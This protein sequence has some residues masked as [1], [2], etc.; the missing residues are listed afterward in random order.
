[1]SSGGASGRDAFD[2]LSNISFGAPESG[3]RSSKKSKSTQPRTVAPVKPGEATRVPKG[4]AVE[5]VEI[6]S[7]NSKSNSHSIDDSPGRVSL[8][9]SH[10]PIEHAP[11][12]VKLRAS[13]SGKTNHR[14]IK[15][16]KAESG[17]KGPQSAAFDFLSGIS[18]GSPN[19]SEFSDRISK[20]F[21]SPPF[22]QPT[23]KGSQSM[24]SDVP[25][26]KA[27]ISSLAATTNNTEPSQEESWRAAS[28]EEEIGVHEATTLLFHHS[29]ASEEPPIFISN[30]Q[31]F[32]AKEFPTV[33]R[34]VV[35]EMLAGRRTMFAFPSATP[36]HTHTSSHPHSHATRHHNT[37]DT[38]NAGP[39]VKS[40][41]A[42]VISSIIC[43]SDHKPS[44]PASVPLTTAPTS[45]VIDHWAERLVVDS[46]TSDDD[47]DASTRHK[48]KPGVRILPFKK[49]AASTS[50]QRY[51]KPTPRNAEI[52][53]EVTARLPLFK[54]PHSHLM[55]SGTI[56]N[57]DGD[58]GADSP[59]PMATPR[60]QKLKS[61]SEDSPRSPTR[62]GTLSAAS[63]VVKASL[64]YPGTTNVSSATLEGQ[65]D[66]KGEND[67]KALGSPL[68]R[69]KTGKAG[70]R[71]VEGV[72]GE[73]RWERGGGVEAGEG[74]GG[75]VV[76]EV[77]VTGE[78]GEEVSTIGASEANM[79]ASAMGVAVEGLSSAT[80][81]TASNAAS[82]V[83]E[84]LVPYE[85]CLKSYD[86][87]FLEHDI[88]PAKYLIKVRLPGYTSS[89]L[90]VKPAKLVRQEENEAFKNRHS[91]LKTD[92]T[93]SKLRSVKRKMEQV[94]ISLTL[95]IACTAFSFVYFEK[96]V[97]RN[98]VSNHNAR[99]YGAVC[100]LLA[101][102]WYGV[103]M[104]SFASLIRELCHKLKLSTK[105]LLSQEF[106]IY[107][108]LKFSLFVEE[109]QV[110]PH[111][112]KLRSSP[113]YL[114]K[115]F[116]VQQKERKKHLRKQHHPSASQNPSLSNNPPLAPPAGA[117]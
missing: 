42:V 94:A 114:D 22:S 102:K 111:F 26:L 80:V 15:D 54:P 109:S 55:N 103:K 47:F 11:T 59:S 37:Q 79:G 76:R 2:F 69:G 5:L 6:K 95:D 104:P 62:P 10:K 72:E 71:E 41:G 64:I 45:R 96:L 24:Q 1:M 70:K 16:A 34:E 32:S 36:P 74:K 107:R 113:N 65:G 13:H 44:I 98:L 19:P 43:P 87:S 48:T 57:T 27:A 7:K 61:F 58:S 8:H 60:S 30:T 39:K 93:L 38:G 12:P 110:M 3:S 20:D 97:L 82:S 31:V 52:N 18:L 23:S 86:P 50:Y 78:E 77:E 46:D 83:F 105:E 28:H 21:T 4:G 33:A 29:I 17:S 81:G 67:A 35:Q 100:L 75:F 9:A 88:E 90:P 25:A 49:K 66:G 73:A 51:L 115:E 99:V 117:K 53:R 68:S 63:S 92:L 14:E 91:W 56:F 85:R 108:K 116:Q 89:I 106:F 40:Y 84:S 112:F 101:A